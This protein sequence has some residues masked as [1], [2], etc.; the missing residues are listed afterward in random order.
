ME[1]SEAILA[2]RTAWA[3]ATRC[4]ETYRIA[5]VEWETALLEARAASEVAQPDWEAMTPEERRG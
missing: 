2:E 4:E 1:R 5:K 3:K